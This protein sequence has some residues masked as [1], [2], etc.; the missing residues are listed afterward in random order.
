MKTANSSPD[1]MSEAK[2]PTDTHRCAPAREA[3]LST[4]LNLEASELE[5]KLG[6]E[7]GNMSGPRLQLAWAGLEP[8]PLIIQSITLRSV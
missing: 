6:M 3:V 7:R 8:G 2:V 4:S 1:V 5:E